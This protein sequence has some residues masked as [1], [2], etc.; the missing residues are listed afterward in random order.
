MEPALADL[1]SELDPAV[2]VI[3]CLWNMQGLED[4]EISGRV[5]NL[6]RAIRRARPRT[7][8]LF[9]GQSNIRADAHPTHAS[10]V[11][12]SAVSALQREGVTGL[13][14]VDGARLLGTDGDGTVDGCHPT[15]LGFMQHAQALLPILRRLIR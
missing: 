15:D 12:Q 5:T 6:A 10:R 14:L 3:D 1:L 7:P 13:E 11:Q 4:R 2:Y 8:I 9:V